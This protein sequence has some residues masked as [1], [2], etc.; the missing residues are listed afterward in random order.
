[1]ERIT[2]RIEVID[3]TVRIE[4]DLPWV[5][6]LLADTVQDAYA[7]AASRYSRGRGTAPKK[8]FLFRLS[9]QYPSQ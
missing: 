7:A 5:M 1:V 2:G 4:I 3:D 9:P 8:T 6:Q